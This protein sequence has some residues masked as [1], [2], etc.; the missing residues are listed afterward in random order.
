MELCY[1]SARNHVLRTLQLRSAGDGDAGVNVRAET[2][3]RLLVN[4]CWDTWTRQVI[5]TSGSP[6]HLFT[7]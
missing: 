6:V 3:R 4:L 5:Q 1:P 2:F 7:L